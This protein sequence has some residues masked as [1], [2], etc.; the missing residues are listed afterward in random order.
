MQVRR[1]V[2]RSG[3]EAEAW[4]G[5]DQETNTYG[6]SLPS[7]CPSLLGRIRDAPFTSHPPNPQ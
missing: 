3:G 5:L 6:R 1:L 4:M 7:L 2:C